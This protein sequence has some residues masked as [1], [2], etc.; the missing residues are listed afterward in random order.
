MFTSVAQ[1]DLQRQQAIATLEQQTALADQARRNAEATKRLRNDYEG[2]TYTLK[3]EL[4]QAAAQRDTVAIDSLPSA[5]TR[6]EALVTELESREAE[7]EATIATVAQDSIATQAK[8]AEPTKPAPSTFSAPAAPPQNNSLFHGRNTDGTPAPPVSRLTFTPAE[9]E[10][11]IEEIFEGRNYGMPAMP[12][13]IMPDGAYETDYG[14]TQSP[15][16]TARINAMERQLAEL[17]GT[18]QEL[19]DK[20]EAAEKSRTVDKEAL[21][22]E[23][24]E[25]TQSILDE[26]RAMRT[27]IGNKSNMTDKK[28]EQLKKTLTRQQKKPS[29]Q[30]LKRPSRK[31]SER[32]KGTR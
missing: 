26:I 24:K 5:I 22:Q 18:V 14:I 17:R 15:Q 10:G 4:K 28:R 29:K 25:S 9:F 27:E 19:S 8:I 6:T 12:L 3:K 1:Q 16:D 30:P 13:E 20:Q 32:R 23:M 31:P 21:R 2:K 7:L 11:L